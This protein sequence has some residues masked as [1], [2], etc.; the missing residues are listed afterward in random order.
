M[1]AQL[2]TLPSEKGKGKSAGRSHYTVDELE[3]L[4]TFN[5]SITQAMARTMQDLSEGIFIN[6]ANLTLAHRDSYL[7]YLRAGLK[8]DTLTALQIAPLHMHSL[9]P[10]QLMVKEE[11][12]VSRNKER[13]S[14]GASQKKPGRY[15]P[16]ASSTDKSSHQPHKRSDVPALKQIM[17]R[18][19]G[20]KGHVKASTYH[21]KLAK[22]SKQHKLQLLCKFCGGTGGLCACVQQS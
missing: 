21:Q 2:K 12:E 6:M 4:V 16:Y 17:D 10:D 22:G 8:Q 20:M 5:R 14:T 13:R 18:Q 9:F 19:Q 3:Y 7:D 1:V 11:E 15:H